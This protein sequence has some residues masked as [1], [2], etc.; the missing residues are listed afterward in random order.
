MYLICCFLISLGDARR[1]QEGKGE[2]HVQEEGR[3]AGGALHVMNCAPVF[4][5][6]TTLCSDNIFG[7]VGYVPRFGE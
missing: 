5:T 4:T 3:R 2:G 6:R 7:I 1:L